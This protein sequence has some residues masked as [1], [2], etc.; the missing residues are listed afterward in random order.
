[1]VVWESD[2]PSLSTPLG[3]TAKDV[4]T[5]CY[6][7][8]PMGTGLRGFA[9]MGWDSDQSMLRDGD[10]HPRVV[11]TLMVVE[12]YA[13]FEDHGVV[14][15][16]PFSTASERRA[17]RCDDCEQSRVPVQEVPACVVLSTRAGT[18]LLH[19]HLKQLG[20]KAAFKL[21]RSVSASVGDAPTTILR[22]TQP[23]G[24]PQGADQPSRMQPFRG[25]SS[26][27]SGYHSD[28]ARVRH[29]RLRSLCDVSMPTPTFAV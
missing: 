17:L 26:T 1:M 16:V 2:P 10:V 5:V 29:Y 15:V 28:D 20:A 18:R 14:A 23:D 19:I 27:A 13:N 6:S 21:F 8:A 22:A 4:R 12:M 11:T 3:S 9:C 7:A 25:V 24:T